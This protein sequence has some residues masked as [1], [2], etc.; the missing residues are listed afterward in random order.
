MKNQYLQINGKS[1]DHGTIYVPLGSADIFF[2]SDFK[3]LEVLYAQSAREKNAMYQEDRL[4][5]GVAKAN[6]YLS[7][8]LPQNDTA[9][10]QS[11]F[12]PLLEDYSNTSFLLS[13]TG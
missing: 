7:A 2:P 1:R 10:T 5:T 3:L 8:F 4:L 12:N 9:T 11:G 13:R 6:E